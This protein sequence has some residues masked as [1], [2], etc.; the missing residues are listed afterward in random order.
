M[1]LELDHVFILVRPG[2]IVADLL[3]SIGMEESFS[4]DHK[5]QGTSNR[6]F[7]FSNGMLELLWVRDAEEAASG[8]GR[9]LHFLKRTENSLFSPFGIILRKKTN[10]HKKMPFDGWS[11]QPDYFL[12]PMSFH[13]GIN[14]KNFIEPLC[15][16][17]P[18][19]EVSSKKMARRTFKAINNV[20]IHTTAKDAS[21]VL[22]IVGKVARLTIATGN[23]HLMEITFDESQLGLSK[24][25][26]PDIPLII[27][28]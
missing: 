8:P 15:I 3:L 28:W 2:A 4:R 24:D 22:N 11:Y 20:K 14:S 25:F 17:A 12:P 27:H 10:A 9:D 5:G 26:R 16:Y 7:E 13:V 1:N 19:I 18:F 6:R 23:E 21:D